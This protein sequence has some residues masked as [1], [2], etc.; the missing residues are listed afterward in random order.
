MYLSKNKPA[1]VEQMITFIEEHHP[2]DLSVAEIA[3]AACISTT[4]ASRCFREVLKIRPI[5]YLN[6]FRLQK[7]KLLLLSTDKSV[8]EIAEETGFSS[9]TYFT[10]LF[11]RM[12]GSTPVEVRN[13]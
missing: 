11:R 6:Q 8:A 9:N 1:R 3:S 4:E 2:E 5:Q 7:A 12:Y 13:N 10:R